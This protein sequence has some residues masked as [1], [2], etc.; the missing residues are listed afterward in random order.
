MHH[1]R[2]RRHVENR[3]DKKPDMVFI[4]GTAFQVGEVALGN[5]SH[6]ALENIPIPIPIRQFSPNVPSNPPNFLKLI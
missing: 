6:G 2:R 1:R 5:G 3:S 4:A